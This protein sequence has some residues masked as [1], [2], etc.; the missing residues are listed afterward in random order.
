MRNGITGIVNTT[1]VNAICTKL[2]QMT[3]I[4]IGFI[5]FNRKIESWGRWKKQKP[6][7]VARWIHYSEN[8]SDP[9]NIDHILEIK[10]INLRFFKNVLHIAYRIRMQDLHYCF[11]YWIYEWLASNIVGQNPP[12][13]TLTR[14]PPSYA[15]SRWPLGAGLLEA[16]Y[17]VVLVFRPPEAI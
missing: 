16:P 17:L 15:A 5:I 7:T 2:K 8:I 4:L 12:A 6:Q 3:L 13:S 9:S 14:W 1:F 10:N 11:I